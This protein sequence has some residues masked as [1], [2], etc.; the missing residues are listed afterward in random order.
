[1]AYDFGSLKLGI[2]NPFKQEGIISTLAGIAIVGI[3]LGPLLSVAGVIQE[4]RTRAWLYA[5]LGLFL[6]V[7][8]LRRAGRGLFQLFRFFVGRSVPTSLAYNCNPSEQDNA[9]A[10]H[11]FTA[12]DAKQLESMLMGRKNTTFTEP[13]GWLSRLLHSLIPSLI[14]TPYPLRNLAQELFGVL[15]VTFTAIIAFAVAS[16]VCAT[17]LAGPVGDL[18]MPLMSVLLLVYMTFVWRATGSRLQSNQ[19]GRLQA[20]GAGGLARLLGFSILLPIII[21]YGYQQLNLDSEQAVQVSQLFELVT[22]NAWPNLSYLGLM[23]IVV[24]AATVVL[25]I[26][27][28]KLSNPTTEVSEYRDN[29]QES[30]HPNE[31]F[32]NTESIVLANR[33]YNEIP[34]RT[35]RAFDP[36]LNDQSEGKGS[37]GGELLI[38][39]QPAY[40]ELEH[41]PLFKLC[42]SAATL[43]GQILLV[44]GVATF[45]SV[46]MNGYDVYLLADSVFLNQLVPALQGVRD[47]TLALEVAAPILTPVADQISGL[48]TLLF[49]SLASTAAGHILSRGANLFWAEM[50]WDSLLMWM[51]MEGTYTESKVS[52]GM[53]IHDSTRSEN[54]V[55][56]SSITPWIISS[57]VRTT[58]FATSGNYNLELPRYILEMQKNDGEL[59][60]IVDEIKSFLRGRE[61][62]A[63]ITN[64]NDLANAKNIYDVNQASRTPLGA[65]Q[66]NGQLNIEEQAAHQQRQ[67]AIEQTD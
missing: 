3:G 28:L 45:A 18:I 5:G 10:E 58:C 13:Q 50:H 65:P 55:V 7:V 43:V 20:K 56:R 61:S 17:G 46:I 16:F 37:F 53:S 1:M 11:R 19:M 60:G 35:Y 62:I 42:R 57:R 51:K 48:I 2:K 59:A 47:E 63:S 67:E 40:R 31:I 27:R 38:E 49:I 44:V 66:Q 36:A 64:E 34:N 4:D 22:F 26:E 14:T 24:L 15:S 25:F 41:S 23:V 29:L 8:G 54:V 32:I 52:T 21:G 39:T 30:I 9:K 12:Y 6:L 33:R